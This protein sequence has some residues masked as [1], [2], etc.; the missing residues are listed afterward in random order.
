MGQT[1]NL[2]LGPQDIRLCPLKLN[3][4]WNNAWRAAATWSKLLA[5]KRYRWIALISFG[6]SRAE[7]GMGTQTPP[8]CPTH[9]SP[10]T[11]NVCNWTV[12]SCAYV[13]ATTLL[14]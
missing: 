2:P 3:L 7:L 4:H 5:C 9:P 10:L 12:A 14:L 13:G 1:L 8:C 6:R 11:G